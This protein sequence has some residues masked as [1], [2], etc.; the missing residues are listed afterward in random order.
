MKLLLVI[1]SLERGG[2]ERV[3]SI[4]ASS[5]AE[6]GHEVT[7]L[8][9]K[10]EVTPAYDLHPDVKLR[11]LGLPG[12]PAANSLLAAF[13]QMAR[14]RAL[15]N[16]MRESQ[17]DLVISFM[18]RTN[19]MTLAAARGLRVPVIVSERVDPRHYDIGLFWNELRALTYRWAAALVCQSRASQ[20]WFE[21]RMR[22]KARVI[23]NPV[24]AVKEGT[25]RL[26]RKS[27]ERHTMVAM[28]RLVDQKGFDLLLDAFGQL[29]DQYPDWNL[30]VMGEGPL[31]AQLLARARALQLE[32]QV[33]FVGEVAD[34]FSVLRGADLFVLASRFEGFPNALCEAM[35]CGV[36]VVSFD[37]PSGPAEIIRHG[38]DGILVPPGD[39]S[40]LAAA[41]DQLMKD[42]DAR[43]RLASRAPEVVER[44][45]RDKVLLLWEQLFKE[46]NS[47]GR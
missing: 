8:T 10:R 3:M 44:F 20:I 14:V 7:L 23:P 9:L 12:E 35:A 47:S 42:Q 26:P 4:L 16:A 40:A 11:N 27:A 39:V 34:P 46:V 32:H 15:R 17:P 21:Q 28:G 22:V 18:E 33:Q 13:R 45:S 19:V 36:A 2:A 43:K 41:L 5:W 25:A 24:P 37:C 30:V 31:R 6:K 38:I 29:A 1:P